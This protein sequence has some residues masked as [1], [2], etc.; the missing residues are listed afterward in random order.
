MLGVISF[1]A[2]SSPFPSCWRP[3]LSSAFRIQSGEGKF[4]RLD[5]IFNKLNRVQLVW[6]RDSDP[7]VV[8]WKIVAL[9]LS[10][11]DTISVVVAV[12]VAN[13]AATVTV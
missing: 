11:E 8:S 9:T 13:I 4:E 5:E 2:F 7:G 10:A 3:P 12:T 1:P 6:S